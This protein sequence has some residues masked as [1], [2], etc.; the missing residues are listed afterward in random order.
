MLKK[1]IIFQWIPL[2]FPSNLYSFAPATL[3]N[4]H[5][6]A[7]QTNGLFVCKLCD[8]IIRNFSF[9]SSQTPYSRA[10]TSSSTCSPSCR[11]SR[12]T[13]WCPMVPSGMTSGQGGFWATMYLF[14]YIFVGEL[15]LRLPRPV[16]GW[17]LIEPHRLSEL[18]LFNTFF[19]ILRFFFFLYFF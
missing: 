5:T 16:G 2:L 14:M 12:S 10:S 18:R 15:F 9:P 8:Y 1:A 6:V 3:L 11:W 13:Q 7:Q 19:C 17:G 4:M